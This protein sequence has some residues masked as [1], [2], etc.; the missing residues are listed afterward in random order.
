MKKRLL[1]GCLSLALAACTLQKRDT[2]AVPEVAV[3]SSFKNDVL[4]GMAPPP[5]VADGA[6]ALPKAVRDIVVVEWWRSFGSGELDALIDRGLAN[7]ADLRI[8]TLRL[9]QVRLRSEQAAAGRLPSLTAPGLMAIQAPG[10]ASAGG[11]PLNGGSGNAPVRAYQGSL[12]AEWRLDVW[13]EQ[14]ALAESAA[15]QV[16]RAAFERDNV[17]RGLVASIASAYIEYISLNDRLRLARETEAV[18]AASLKSIQKRTEAGDA[19]LTDLEQQRSAIFAVRAYMPMLEQQREEARNALSFLVGTVPGQLQLSEAGLDTLALPKVLPGMPAAL[20]LRRPDVRMVEARML[21]ADADI[22]VARARILPSVDLSSQLGF[23]SLFLSTLFTPQTLFWNTLANLSA[24]IFDGGKR[25]AEREISQ[26]IHEELVE[27]Y[28]RSIYLAIREV[29]TAL[30]TIQLSGK[31]LD[32][33]GEAMRS[34]RRAWQ[35]SGEVYA[36]GA[37]DYLTLL[38]TERTYHRQLDEYQRIRMDYVRAYINLFNALGGGVQQGDALPGTTPRSVVQAEPRLQVERTEPAQAAPAVS[39]G[40]RL[41]EDSA[42]KP[43]EYWLVE[44]P[45]LYHR[46]TISAVWRDL[47]ARFPTWMR[48]RVVK[49]QL[50]GRIEESVDAREAWFRLSVAQFD[51]SA[52]AEA[53]CLALQTGQQRCRIVSSRGNEVVKSAAE[54]PVA[55]APAAL[56]TPE[57]SGKSALSKA[58]GGSREETGLASSRLESSRPE[59]ASFAVQLAVFPTLDA[60]ARNSRLWE[61]KG[62]TPYVV[63]FRNPA[64]REFFAVRVGEYAQRSAAEREAGRI[65]S[66]EKIVASVVSAFSVDAVDGTDGG[67]P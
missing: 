1:L 18:L 24:S 15:L 25:R 35:I 46:T 20:I 41:T 40:I 63:P 14:S 51:S 57:E 36:S 17:Q 43:E 31:R 32:A 28:I 59:E 53:F 64:G 12:R 39:T 4:K 10:G 47:R 48:D 16:W 8:A 7:N 37:V 5:N 42:G 11:I 58:E 65:G 13:G 60:A 3:P 30:S 54:A 61:Q 50:V 67:R 33:Q 66:R 6:A 9:A 27:T 55:S 23:S 22:D 34:A 45:G 2:Y 62:Y 38:D 29:E 19:T 44:L 26:S 52:S 56:S 49:P 21:A